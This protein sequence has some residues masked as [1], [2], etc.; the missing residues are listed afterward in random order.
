MIPN[1]FREA[2]GFCE[3]NDSRIAESPM[4]W[5]STF[6]LLYFVATAG[7]IPAADETIKRRIAVA[8]IQFQPQGSVQKNTDL[9]IE[10]LEECSKKDV[11]E[12]GRAHV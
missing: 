3:Y 8:A 9:I 4:R 7:Y 2:V 5:F 12:I 11:R 6:I 1:V 10:Y